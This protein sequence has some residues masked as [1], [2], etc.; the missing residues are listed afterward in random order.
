M[1]LTLPSRPA[2]YFIDEVLLNEWRPRDALGYDLRANPDEEMFIPVATTIDNVGAV[3]PSLV[4]QYSNETSGGQSTYDF[5]TDNG[6]GQRRQGTLLA[7]AR[8]Q[9]KQNGYQADLGWGEEAWGDGTW[10][11]EDSTTVSAEALV[12]FLTDAVENVCQRRADAPQTD[13]ETLGSQPGP[14]V[15]VDYGQDGTEPPVRISQVEI[16]YSWVRAP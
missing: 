2:Q 6:P 16:S 15:P 14:D 8:A 1:G 5:M 10:S 3:Y 11:G 13:F 12:Y 7:T 4:V 9:D